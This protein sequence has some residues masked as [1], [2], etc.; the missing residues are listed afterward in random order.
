[1]QNLLLL[2]SIVLPHH[3]VIAKAG[4]QH[5]I[6]DAQHCGG[7]CHGTTTMSAE[8]E[9]AYVSVE[10]EG[11]DEDDAEEETLRSV[12]NRTGSKKKSLVEAWWDRFL[13]VTLSDISTLPPAAYEM[14]SQD[15]AT[16]IAALNLTLMS[17]PTSNDMVEDGP[18]KGEGESNFT[19]ERQQQLLS[20]RILFMYNMGLADALR[21]IMH[22]F[23]YAVT[24]H[25]DPSQWRIHA[26]V[27]HGTQP[28]PNQQ[29]SSS[30]SSSSSSWSPP[31]RR[32]H[33]LS[34]R[35]IDTLH[36]HFTAQYPHTALDR[37][38]FA[39]QLKEWRRLGSIY[40]FIA[41][42]LGWGSLLYLQAFI[43]PSRCWGAS[44][45]GEK[46][47][48]SERA[49]KHLEGIGLVALCEAKG[50]NAC[51]RGLLVELCKDFGQFV[52]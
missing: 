34:P 25:P 10:H 6:E 40:M 33:R 36:A 8:C 49:F 30:S 7:P 3:T 51:V 21:I 27:D 43:V 50:A 45:G 13:A 42:R 48:A 41:R 1:M 19:R 20:T 18:G 17:S 28:H 5:L 16:T 29:S 39:L 24:Y 32:L 4:L 14:L 22:I 23:F 37:S 52:F 26:G 15:A 2:N 35:D 46:S 44:K 38:T 9:Q 31:K 47:G 12:S 11:D